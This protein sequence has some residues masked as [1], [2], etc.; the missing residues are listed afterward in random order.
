MKLPQQ[1]IQSLQNLPGFSET[2]FIQAHENPQQLTSIRVNQAKKNQQNHSFSV[3]DQ[4]LPITETFSN[5]QS[6]PWCADGWYLPERPSFTLD[7]FFHAG[8]Y[9]V[10][11]ASSM[12]IEQAVKKAFPDHLDK[13]YRILDLCAAPGGKS[14]HLAALFPQGLVVAN[15]VIKTRAGI[16][17]ENAIKWGTGNIVVS[18]NDSADFKNLEGYFDMVLVDAPC[19]GSG[20]FRKDEEAISEWSPENVLHCCKRQQRILEDVWPCLK[21]NGLLIYSTCSY[22]QLENEDITDWLGKNFSVTNIQLPLKEEW[23]IVETQSTDL[24]YYGYRF[25][26]DKTK[27]EGFFTSCFHKNAAANEPAKRLK[28]KLNMVSRVEEALLNQQIN[29]PYQRSYFYLEDEI[30]SFPEPWLEDLTEL[31]A[32]IYVKK[33]GIRVGKIIKNEL[34]PDHELA[35][36]TLITNGFEFLELDIQNA[37]QYLRKQDINIQTSF[38]GWTLITY[39]SFCLGWVKVLPNRINNYYPQRFRILKH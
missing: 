30:I 36:S 25:Y 27:G 18:S 33:A 29:A 9:Y 11:E 3:T 17:V 23:R 15:E 32:L 24:G 13:P 6:I 28:K 37:L 39:G 1:L 38:K 12:F 31:L 35:I 8:C 2:A 4:Q 26:P 22:S 7:P 16:L 34:V 5:A 14:T 19:S 20:M 10:Q 21:E